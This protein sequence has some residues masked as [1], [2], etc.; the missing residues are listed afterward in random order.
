MD[1]K[2][3]YPDRV[4]KGEDGVWRWTGVISRSENRHAISVTLKVVGAMCLFL[5]VLSA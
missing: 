3:K 2:A 5:I 1:T 4:T